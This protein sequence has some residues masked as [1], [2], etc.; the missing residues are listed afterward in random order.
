MS[1]NISRH[2]GV[3]D[4]FVRTRAALHAVAEHVLAAARYRAIGRIGLVVTPGGFGTPPFGAEERVVAV[5]GTDLV[6]RSGGTDGASAV[7]RAPLRTLAAA[8]AL[9]GLPA[10]GGPADVYHLNTPCDPDAALDVD[11]DAARRIADW[12]ALGDAALRQW[13]AE[14]PADEPSGVTLWP[15]HADVAIRAADI[16]YGASPGDDYVS[17][18]YLYVGPPAPPPP[19]EDGFWNAPF[20]AFLTWDKVSSVAD[21]VDFFRQGRQ[22]ARR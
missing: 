15:E 22:L 4:T 10:P 9:T 19:T 7:R 12:Y 3:D 13:C 5:D 14:I 1:E 16:N 20:G 18:P 8:A 6:V 2:S 17:E 21:A 11:P